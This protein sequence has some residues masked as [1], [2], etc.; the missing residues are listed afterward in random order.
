MNEIFVLPVGLLLSSV[1]LSWVS[2]SSSSA[3]CTGGGDAERRCSGELLSTL[4]A[5]VAAL[6]LASCRVGP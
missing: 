3:A 1:T 4:R 5:L 2:S 6:C